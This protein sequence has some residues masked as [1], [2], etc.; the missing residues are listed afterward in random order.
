MLPG[1]ET[2]ALSEPPPVDN[3]HI[4]HDDVPTKALFS[5]RWTLH[6]N[7]GVERF[8]SNP[9]TST[10]EEPQHKGH[11]VVSPLRDPCCY[12]SFGVPK[13]RSLLEPQ[14]SS[15]VERKRSVLELIEERTN[16][17]LED[18]RTNEEPWMPLAVRVASYAAAFLVFQAPLGALV[19]GAATNHC[20]RAWGQPS[21]VRWQVL[22]EA[23]LT[24]EQFERLVRARNKL[25]TCRQ[26]LKVTV[27]QIERVCTAL[28]HTAREKDELKE[29][30]FQAVKEQDQNTANQWFRVYHSAGEMLEQ[31]QTLLSCLRARR[32][33]LSRE[34]DQ[35]RQRY[36]KMEADLWFVITTKNTRL[37]Y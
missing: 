2:G 17:R 37:T 5:T 8:S 28:E 15:L 19:G 13:R 29:N 35:L 6:K 1:V 11:E 31:G 24:L 34:Q 25:E 7:H 4:H 27:H 3:G 21:W 16:E 9:T 18:F 20:V 10:I 26:E 36:E 14:R 32:D 22:Q 33:A 12:R 23:G 30:I